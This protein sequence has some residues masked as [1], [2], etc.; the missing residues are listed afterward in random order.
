MYEK[1]YPSKRFKFTVE[2]VNKHITKSEMIL[3][4]GVSNPLSEILKN[5]G[6]SITNTSG[7]DLDKDQK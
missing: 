5:E 6:Y 1:T 2:F 4:L 3:D 7:E